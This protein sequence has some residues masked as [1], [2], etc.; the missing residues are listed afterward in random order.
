MVKGMA[1]S[2]ALEQKAPDK[3]LK[4][5]ANTYANRYKEGS[6]IEEVDQKRSQENTWPETIAKKKER[7]DSDTRGKPDEGGKA[8]DR[9]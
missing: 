2:I 4:G 8:T 6:P 7:R 1:K 3:G 5:I 9:I